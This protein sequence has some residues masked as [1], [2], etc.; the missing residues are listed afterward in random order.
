MIDNWDGQVDE[1]GYDC[2]FIQ[3]QQKLPFIGNK[4]KPKT[5][6]EKGYT[7]ND[8][9]KDT[10]LIQDLWKNQ[11]SIFN[12]VKGRLNPFWILLDNHL[13]VHLFC[14]TIFLQSIRMVEKE[15]HQYINI[16]MSV[17]NEVGELPGFGTSG[18]HRD[19]IANTLAIIQGCK[20]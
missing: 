8:W 7:V 10:I 20:S 17:I 14:N 6:E 5:K 3:H 18:L 12:K 19:G 13:T 4:P 2:L 16:G 15:L 11:P 1:E 9:M